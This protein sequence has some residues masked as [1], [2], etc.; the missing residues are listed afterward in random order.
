MTDWLGAQLTALEGGYSGETYVVGDD[1]YRVVVRI[2][3]R[4]PDRAVVD[5][6]LLRLVR[7]LVPV[8][9]VVELRRPDGADP[10]VLVTEYVVGA[11]LDLALAEEPPWLDLDALGRSLADLLTTL[12]GIPFL[13]S[14]AF[15]DADL[16]LSRDGLAG[17][18]QDWAGR[19]RDEGRL[20]SW[21]VP[22]WEALQRLVDLAED[23]LADEEGR[24]PP[25][26]VLAHSDL[27][28]KNILVD[29]RTSSVVALLDWEFA[30]AGS[31][32]T[33]IGNLCRFERDPRLVEPLLGHLSLPAGGRSGDHLELGRAMD[34]WA[35]VELAG[36]PIPGPV[37]DLAA[38][39]LLAQARAGD[40][41]AWPWTAAR[42]APQHRPHA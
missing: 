16:T 6:S 1:P 41:G 40:L 17:D 15:E 18:L 9:A 38:E 14:G 37:N 3:R 31:P 12:G 23:L 19:Q 27:N 34:L 42:V 8:P 2:Y 21:S 33:D 29:P 26:V 35:L 7:G 22:D 25:R 13:R 28:P 36:R 10:A 4:S 5:A 11:R 24:R 30:H 32:H 20:A 39:L